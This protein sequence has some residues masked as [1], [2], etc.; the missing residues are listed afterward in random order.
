M[1]ANKVNAFKVTASKVKAQRGFSLLE[2]LIAMAIFTLIGVASTGLLTTVIDS[3]KLS[4]ERFDKLQQMQRA[5]LIIERDI[6]QA[7]ARPV[8]IEGEVSEVVMQGGLNT[9]S[10]GDGLTFVRSGWLNPQFMLPRSTLERVSYRMLENRLERL[11]SHYLDNPIG[12]EPKIRVLLDDVTDFRVEFFVGDTKNKE[13]EW[14]E[15]YTGGVLPHGIALEIETNT[16]GLIRREFDMV[17]AAVAASSQAQNNSNGQQSGTSDDNST[18]GANTNG[19]SPSAN[20]PARR[21]RQ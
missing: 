21:R 18:N 14:R 7:I 4:G 3:N 16:F 15:S 5:M 13:L 17:E 19:N 9:E 2:I 12:Y 1:K 20:P 11:S 6:Q 10:D 8:R